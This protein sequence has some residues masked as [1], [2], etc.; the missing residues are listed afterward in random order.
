MANLC[1]NYVTLSGKNAT[2]LFNDLTAFKAKENPN[3]FAIHFWYTTFYEFLGQKVGVDVPLPNAEDAPHSY[4]VFGSRYFHCEFS[5]EG[6]NCI[7][8]S[9]ESAWSP[10]VPFIHL[11]CQ[12][13]SLTANGEYEES[14]LDF[15]GFFTIDEDQQLTDKD[16]SYNAYRY[17]S[18][19]DYF[20]EW[21]C[22]NA[23]FGYY[24]TIEEVY[25]QFDIEGARPL[26]NDEKVEL[27][28]AFNE[29]K[30]DN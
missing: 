26:T 23:S 2:Q 13:Y 20:F 8:M 4:D 3:D 7:Y 11:I 21:I 18:E 17:Y 16:M 28:E 5:M 30:L 27:L 12:K 6:D 15:G 14:G 9:G 19:P 10:V 24:D 25:K 29:S 22:E 1:S